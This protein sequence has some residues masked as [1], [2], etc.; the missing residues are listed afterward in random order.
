MAESKSFAE[1]DD[2]EA[3]SSDGAFIVDLEG[4]EGQG[5]P[6]TNACFVVLTNVVPP[7]FV[8]I[9]SSNGYSITSSPEC[10]V[11]A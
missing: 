9:C 6:G 8:S 10:L 1:E 2:F 11:H 5:T 7:N 4:Y 3:P